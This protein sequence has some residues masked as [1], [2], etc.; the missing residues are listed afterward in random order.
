MSDKRR[1]PAN[2]ALPIANELIA[3]LQPRASKF[4]LPVRYAAVSP[5]SVIS[6]FFMFRV[7]LRCASLM[8]C[9]RE[10]TRSATNC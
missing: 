10:P 9:F 4:A 6:R 3:Q 5:K 7:W 8:S 2:I 1:W